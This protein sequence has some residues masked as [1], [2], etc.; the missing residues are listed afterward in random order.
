MDLV[1]DLLLGFLHAIRSFSSLALRLIRAAVGFV[2]PMVGLVDGPFCIVR[3][4]LGV[5]LVLPGFRPVLLL[6]GPGHRR[7]QGKRTKTQQLHHKAAKSPHITPT[8]QEPD[9]IAGA[10]MVV[11]MVIV[12]LVVMV[13]V[14]VV[15]V[16]PVQ[17]PAS[18]G[19]ERQ[20]G[21]RQHVEQ[22]KEWFRMHKALLGAITG[23]GHKELPLRH[24]VK[25]DG[26]RHGCTAAV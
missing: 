5:C 9:R 17:T 23:R 12:M 18:K 15:V 1:A 8:F 6:A 10:S 26:C 7:V 2:D 13:I 16:V 21:Q 24:D 25:A 4:L 20:G 11:M 19:A 14:M 22:P 3:I